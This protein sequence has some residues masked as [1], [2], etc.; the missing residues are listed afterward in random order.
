MSETSTAGPLPGG[1]FQI[2]QAEL[3]DCQQ[4]IGY[5]FKTPDHLA[6]ALIHS[7]V[8]NSRLESNERMEFLGDAVLGLVI[9]EALYQRFPDYLE[10]ELTKLKSLLV[11]RK[12]CAQVAEELR[13]ADFLVLGKGMHGRAHLPR[14]LPAAGLEALIAAVYADGGLEAAREFILASFA[15]AIEEAIA[16]THLRNYKSVLQQFAQH[17]FERAPVYDVLDEKGPD[18][19]KCFEVSVRIGE[20]RFGSAW[21]PSK[22][23]AEQAAAK[24]ALH[25][26]SNEHDDPLLKV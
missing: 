22:K 8:A 20:R 25:E 6:A 19:A 9:C 11:S 1:P 17:L 3:E 5:R 23:E 7:S 10:G 13:L 4:A 18:H 16:S 12:T 21:G 24:L 2:A 15:P 14:S 26:L